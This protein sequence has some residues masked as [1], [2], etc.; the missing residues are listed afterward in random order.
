MTNT[1]LTSVTSNTTQAADDVAPA[2]PS[3]ARHLSAA[4]VDLLQRRAPSLP[5]PVI[6]RVGEVMTKQADGDS[7]ITIEGAPVGA[8]PGII[9]QL[10]ATDLRH[11]GSAAEVSAL[12]ANVPF[13]SFDQRFYSQRQFLDEVSVA[14]SIRRLL[15]A[16]DDLSAHVAEERLDALLR[17]P[18]K[19]DYLTPLDIGRRVL[20][21]NFN[22]LVG[23]PGTGK[24]HN[25]TR[26]LALVTEAFLA[27][28]VT[29][30]I[31]VCAPTGKASTR[32]GEMIDAF[33]K[34]DVDLPVAVRST[35]AG[36]TPTTVH[37]LLGSLPGRSMRFRHD[38][39]TPLELDLLVVDEMSMVP[40]PLAARLFEAVPDSCRVLLVGDE[41]QLESIEIGAVLSQ[42]TS[43]NCPS[44]VRD[45]VGTLTLTFR[46]SEHSVINEAA[47]AM[48]RGDAA[49]FF[50]RISVKGTD[51]EW[52]ETGPVA[53]IEPAAIDRVAA[54]LEP[55]VVLARSTSTEDHVVA[56]ATIAGVKVLC[57][58]REGV[59]GVRRWNDAIA[60]RLGLPRSGSPAAGTPLL[61]TVNS[62]ALRLV[63]GSIG[64]VVHTDQGVRV[65]FP[66]SALDDGGNEVK[67]ARYL[68]LSELPPHEPCF[69]MTVHKSQGSE[70]G[71]LVVMVVPHHDSQILC[72]ELVYTGITRAK[73]EL[74]IVGSRRAL[75]VALATA[76]Q[77]TSG[78]AAMLDLLLG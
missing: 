69:A 67:S 9:T 32:A 52:L 65:A 12:V 47:G 10:H 28:G 76:T 15:A 75:E 45:R 53:R 64:L 27:R 37:R 66:T 16:S 42:L 77:R 60:A 30:R 8:V 56:L 22:V 11:A 35:L 14:M 5:Q 50:Q 54:L 40:L 29:P 49:D 51:T 63:N 4:I 46:Q 19:P 58:P 23:G 43:S 24:T 62:P 48:R 68:T 70:Y 34:S 74:M 71:E 20:S 41:A 57:G 21:S 44:A 2:R 73:K 26:Y 6:D 59:F 78:L 1:S 31:A 36:I 18:L 39:A 33:V 61:V 55:A 13:V 3:E 72:R 17:S 38:A 7:C 25:L